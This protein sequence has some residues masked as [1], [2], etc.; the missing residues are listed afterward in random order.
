MAD[1]VLVVTD[2]STTGVKNARLLQ[3]V[4]GVL[5]VDPARFVLVV[6]H[7]DGAGELER[8]YV[9]N[10]LKTEASAEIPYDPNVVATSIAR[11]VPFVLS[12]PQSQAALRI[13][14]LA[15]LLS[16]AVPRRG[17]P[18]AGAAS[19]DPAPHK[20]RRRLGIGRSRSGQAAASD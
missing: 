8:G 9:E 16:S 10:L 6:N 18:E 2:L 13:A 3:T 20:R 15:S 5:K 7:R 14:G 17:H 4:M 1:K 19:L 12:Q 11:G